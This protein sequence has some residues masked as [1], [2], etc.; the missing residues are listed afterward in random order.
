MLWNSV[1][2]LMQAIWLAIVVECTLL[3]LAKQRQMAL[4][5]MCGTRKCVSVA[6]I[7][8]QRVSTNSTLTKAM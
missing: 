6:K 5:Y 2:Q 7:T 4:L 8:V 3:L 1:L